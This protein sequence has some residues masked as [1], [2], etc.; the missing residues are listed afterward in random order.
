MEFKDVCFLVNFFQMLSYNQF[1]LKCEI[2][3]LAI[4]LTAKQ[5]IIIVDWEHLIKL[6]VT[7]L[8]ET[9]VGKDANPT[10]ALCYVW[11]LQCSSETKR[12][13]H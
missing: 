13:F 8:Y 9:W 10:F 2:E 6:A 1:F 12:I 4:V 3:N 5:N 7:S 11:F